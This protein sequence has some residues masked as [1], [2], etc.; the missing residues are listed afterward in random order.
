MEF[1]KKRR[2]E[3][4]ERKN[5]RARGAQVFLLLGFASA[6]VSL[7]LFFL[8]TFSNLEYFLEDSFF[9]KKPIHDDVVIVAIDH[10]SLARI[11]QFPWPREVFARA[12]QNADALSPKAIGVDVVFADP[13]RFGEKDDRALENALSK[14]HSPVIFPSEGGNLAFRKDGEEGDIPEALS[15]VLPLGRFRSASSV[16][17]GHTNLLV[18]KDGVVRRFPLKIRYFEGTS[19]PQILPSFAGLLLEKGYGRFLEAE[20]GSPRIVFSAPPGG[21]RRIPF[22]RLAEGALP[23]DLSG[24]V[25]LIGSTAPDLHDEKLTAF[26]RGA[27]MPGVEIHAHILNASLMGY[28][29]L[30]LPFPL[31]VFWVALTGILPAF[32]F[33]RI[34]KISLILSLCLSLALLSFAFAAFLF[35]RGFS[36]NVLHATFPAVF[37]AVLMLAARY[38]FTERKRREVERIFSKYVSKDVL[39]LLLEHPEAVKLGGEERDVT[40]FFSD[41][42]GFTTLS[43]KTTPTELVSLLNRYFSKMSEAVLS[44]GGVLDKYIGDAIMAFWGAPVEDSK[45]ADHAVLAALS[46]MEQLSR[47]NEELQKEKGITIDIGIG[48]YSGKAVVGNIGSESRY[49]YTVMGDTVNIASRLEGLNKEHKTHIIIGESTKEKLQGKYE[50]RSLGHV[51]VKGRLK[52]LSIYSVEGKMEEKED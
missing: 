21:I 5:T 27:E 45:Q 29:L 4:E 9:F 31:F 44:E 15:L 10:E 20:E 25:L 22:W 7:V 41:I 50:L 40:V 51:S 26:S 43:E 8:G 11:G 46:M 48:I 36:A 19:A 49:D 32:F 13:S 16:S 38:A 39:N 2:G 14:I 30:P 1:W 47:L 52:P 17:F 42:R 37:S 3:T 18:D 23:S 12:L 34:R 33:L 24:K 35:G 28:R 6:S